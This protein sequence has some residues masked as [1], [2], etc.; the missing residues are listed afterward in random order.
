MENFISG[1]Y[2]STLSAGDT[3]V[4]LN[5]SLLTDNFDQTTDY[6]IL[7]LYLTTD[8]YEHGVQKGSITTYVVPIF[9]PGMKYLI[10]YQGK[11]SSSIAL[12]SSAL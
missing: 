2:S 7:H 3:Q 8:S 11:Y 10:V 5:I 1:R 4:I 12:V 6:V 9:K